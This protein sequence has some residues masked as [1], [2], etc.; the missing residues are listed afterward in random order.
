MESC[1]LVLTVSSGVGRDVWDYGEHFWAAFSQTFLDKSYWTFSRGRGV[2]EGCGTPL[3]PSQGDAGAVGAGG[4]CSRWELTIIIWGP[5]VAT[6]EDSCRFQMP[7]SLL[8]FSD[9]F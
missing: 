1:F 7:N 4:C 8:Q 6:N 5:K 3:W 9:L 2:Q